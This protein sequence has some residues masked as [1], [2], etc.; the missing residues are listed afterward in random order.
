M[1]EIVDTTQLISG[2]DWLASKKAPPLIYTTWGG[3]RRQGET[4]TGTGRGKWSKSTGSVQ[5]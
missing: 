4:G 1:R 3:G 5:L 2:T